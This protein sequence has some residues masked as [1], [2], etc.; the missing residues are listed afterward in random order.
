MRG[1]AIHG[2]YAIVGLSKP[3][4]ERFEGLELDKNL[5]DKDSEAWC[6]VQFINLKNGNVE[7]W[8]RLD[9]PVSE[10]FD[11]TVLPGV[12]CPMGIGQQ[13]KENLTM[14][15]FEDATGTSAGASD[16]A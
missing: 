13:S 5:A 12:R 7:H 16:A 6:G 11:L 2:D 9:G 3:R 4:Y 8:I 1:L 14:V 15:T 10:L